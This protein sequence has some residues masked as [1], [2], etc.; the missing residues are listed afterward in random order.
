[1][2]HHIGFPVNNTPILILDTWEHAFFLDYQTNR[3]GYIDV[4]F[5]N[6]NWDVVNERLSRTLA[7]S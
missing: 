5:N 7:K 6:I 1:M 3:G 4:F 2:E